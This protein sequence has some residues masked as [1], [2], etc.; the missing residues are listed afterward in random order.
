[1]REDL[2]L[3]FAEISEL[4]GC[5]VN[6]AKSRMRYALEHLRKTLKREGITKSEVIEGEVSRM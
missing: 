5:P 3:S 2:N 1:M 4:I 6:T